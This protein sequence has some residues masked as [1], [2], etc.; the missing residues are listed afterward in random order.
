MS[1]EQFLS[2]SDLAATGSAIQSARLRIQE[3]TQKKLEELKQEVEQKKN[4]TGA[5]KSAS[6]G[7]PGRLA[8]LPTPV[9]Q[10]FNEQDRF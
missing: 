9:T 4:P 8:P 7:R 10:I 6:E 5:E 3:N 1:L 2:T